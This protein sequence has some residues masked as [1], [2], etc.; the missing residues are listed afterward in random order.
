MHTYSYCDWTPCT[1]QLASTV[2]K[3]WSNPNKDSGFIDCASLLG[4]DFMTA[5]RGIYNPDD[6]HWT[7][8]EDT[9]VPYSMYNKW[10]ADNSFS[11]PACKNYTM[12]IACLNEF[13]PCM[14]T[15]NYAP[16]LCSD[17]IV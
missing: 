4:D 13:F 10:A 9:E 3:H 14:D 12:T 17:G 8:C 5:P 6:N 11:P 16:F 7:C 1:C 2:A 15:D